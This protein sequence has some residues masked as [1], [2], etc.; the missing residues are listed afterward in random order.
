MA[1]FFSCGPQFSHA[2]SGDFAV[3]R[4]RP[5]QGNRFTFEPQTFQVKLDPIVY[6]LFEFLTAGEMSLREGISF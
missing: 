5:W 2:L 1:G 4:F 3:S 6:V